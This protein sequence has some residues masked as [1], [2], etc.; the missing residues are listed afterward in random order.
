MTDDPDTQKFEMESEM[1]SLNDE[2]IA[3]DTLDERVE[4]STVRALW[5]CYC[6]GFHC[7]SYS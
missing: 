4:F 7:S 5:D 2:D 3:I 6:D 1:E